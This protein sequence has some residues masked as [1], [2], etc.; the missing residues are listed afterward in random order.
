VAILDEN[1]FDLAVL[2]FASILA[3]LAACPAGIWIARRMDIIDYPGRT[4]HQIHQKPT[5]RAGGIALALAM[6]VMFLVNRLWVY[7]EIIQIILPAIIVFAFGLWDDKFGMNAPVKLIGQLVAVTALILLGVRVQFLENP[8]FFIRLDNSLAF[9]LNILITYLWM[10]GI[11]NATNMVDSMDGLAVGLCQIISAFFIVLAM[12][13][14]QP[15]LVILS[16]IL[17]GIT[18]G[19]GFF[20]RQPAKTFLGDSGAQTLGFVLAAAA[21]IYH[22]RSP[23]QASSWFAPI[24]FFSVP[25]FDTTLV[26]ISRALKKQ[27][28]YKANLDHTYHRLV[29]KGWDASRAVGALHLAGMFGGL[30]ATCAMYLPPVYSNMIFLFCLILD[31]VLLQY[32]I[33]SEIA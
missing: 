30:L 8:Q 26:T 7:P 25:I 9:G 2:I 23:S 27:P 29:E 4:A 6:L 1:Y 21:L 10:V 3:G 20:N 14:G 28:F 18:W 33:R 24:L 16:T 11:T 5:P 15:F 32:F 12:I 22:P 17:F 13:S 19:V 31:G